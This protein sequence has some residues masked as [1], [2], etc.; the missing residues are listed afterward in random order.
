MADGMITSYSDSLLYLETPELTIK[1]E[2]RQF[3]ISFNIAPTGLT[4]M[5][6]R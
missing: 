1:I 3:H 6:L 2:G 5:I 4:D